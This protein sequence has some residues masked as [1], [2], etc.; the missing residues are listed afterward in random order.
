[1]TIESPI[2]RVMKYE[3][4]RYGCLRKVRVLVASKFVS[5][6]IYAVEKTVH[7]CSIALGG[8]EFVKRPN[9]ESGL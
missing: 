4:G 9:S 8:R 3:N 1:M 2:P 7:L 6:Y 5:Y